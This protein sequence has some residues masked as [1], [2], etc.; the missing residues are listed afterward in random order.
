MDLELTSEQRQLRE[1]CREFAND[2]IAPRAEQW[3]LA[4]EFPCD[5]F[6]QMGELGLCGPLVPHEY[7][8]AAIGMVG[9]VVAMEQL[10][11][12]DQSLAAGWNA[13][14]MAHGFPRVR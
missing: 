12:G 6:Q 4:H 11:Q 7:G 14:R 5:V 2:V 3:N 8:G 13:S 1:L 10:G 9:Y